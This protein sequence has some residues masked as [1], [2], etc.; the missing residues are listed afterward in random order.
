LNNTKISIGKG[1]SKR[2]LKPEAVVE[3]TT[4]RRPNQKRR[5]ALAAAALADSLAEE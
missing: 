5:A 4:S 3:I 1:G 2:D